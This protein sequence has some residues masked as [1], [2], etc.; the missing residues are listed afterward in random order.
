AAADVSESIGNLM[1]SLSEAMYTT[2]IAL[3]ISIALILLAAPLKMQLKR[4]NLQLRQVH[5]G[6]SMHDQ[7]EV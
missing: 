3:M 5:Q 7:E 6:L 4:I 2:A 1:G